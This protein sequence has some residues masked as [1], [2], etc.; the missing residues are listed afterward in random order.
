MMAL[1]R[2][3]TI[4]GMEAVG[5]DINAEHLVHMKDLRKNFNLAPSAPEIP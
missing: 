1:G 4:N 5:I 3:A 2:D